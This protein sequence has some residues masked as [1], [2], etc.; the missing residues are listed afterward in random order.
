MSPVRTAEGELLGRIVVFRDL[1][2]QRQ[3][4][5]ELR[6][7][8]LRGSALAVLGCRALAKGRDSASS[9]DTLLHETLEA[10]RRLLGLDRARILEVEAEGKLALKAASPEDDVATLPAGGGSLAGYTVLARAAVVVEDVD[11]ERR[12]DTASL[13]PD[14]RSAIAA[15]VFG[16][17]GVWGVLTGQSS[18]PCAFDSA[19]VDFIQSLANIVGT[20]LK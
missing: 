20:A 1:T 18:T 10:M 11:T 19:A 3:L 2:D 4:E 6:T 9:D 16:A 17:E 7:R 12:F 8:Q 13:A 5:D 14:T 15:P